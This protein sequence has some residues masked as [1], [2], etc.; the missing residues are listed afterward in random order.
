MKRLIFVLLLNFTLL[1]WLVDAQSAIPITYFGMHDNKTSNWP[2]LPFGALRLWDS[3]T[4]WSKI[5]TSAGTY[6]F[7]HL[8]AFIAEARANGATDILWS[9]SVTPTFY[10][11]NATDT[12]CNYTAGGCWAPT[13]IDSGNTHYQNFLT[14]VINHLGPGVIKYYEGWNEPN[15]P[16]M[17]S[18][19]VA[20][21]QVMQTMLFNTVR[22]LD[23]SAKVLMPASFSSYIQTMVNNGFGA[24]SDINTFHGK[25]CTP[26]DAVADNSNI[27]S[28]YASAGLGSRPLWNTEAGWGQN[29]G[30]NP[31]SDSANYP[32][33]VAR[34][35][36]LSWSGGIGRY[37]WYAYDNTVWGQLGS[38]QTL[39]AAGIAYKQVSNWMVG[40]SGGNCSS[41]S[42][43]WTCNFTRT[44]P[45]GYQA[46]A[47]WYT[48]GTTSYTVPA[49]SSTERDLSGN[50][51]SVSGGQSIQINGNPV[52]LESIQSSSPSPPTG[53]TVKVN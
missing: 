34:L 48:A 13:D 26:E 9:P 11:S 14:A 46:Q 32:N 25:H 40:A 7:S 36:L 3:A 22:S 17:W 15:N 53:L 39:N 10:S 6:D 24:I 18:D 20:H 4:Q 41:S 43:V 8:D 31:C 5:E 47:V 37:Y 52:L 42:N 21:L 49:G 23:P 12:T 29:G 28:I 35:Y 51:F 27:T 16:R 2:P 38:G 45:D 50:A 44:S 1:C 33:K 30:S 19:T